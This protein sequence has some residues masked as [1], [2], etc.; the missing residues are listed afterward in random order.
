MRNCSGDKLDRS[1]QRKTAFIHLFIQLFI[2][3]TDL[4]STCFLWALCQV[5]EIKVPVNREFQKGGD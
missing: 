4:L 5:L 1:L 3:P 2:Y